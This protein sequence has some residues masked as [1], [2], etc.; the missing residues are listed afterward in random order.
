MSEFEML[1]KQ[2]CLAN[3]LRRKVTE[4]YSKPEN[5]ERIEELKRSLAVQ[6]DKEG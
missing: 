1:V 2:K 3:T 4:Y 5:R 6:D